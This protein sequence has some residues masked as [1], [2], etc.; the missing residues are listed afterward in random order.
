MILPAGGLMSQAINVDRCAKEGTLSDQTVTEGNDIESQVERLPQAVPQSEHSEYRSLARRWLASAGRESP[1]PQRMAVARGYFKLLAAGVWGVEENWRGDLRD[2]LCALW[3]SDEDQTNASSEQLADLSS[4]IAIGLALLLQEANLH[5]GA[6]ADLIARFAW[7]ECQEWA[8]YAEE[9][10]IARFLVPS[11]QPHARV[12][13]E[14]EVQAVVELAMAAADDPNA[15]VIAALDAEGF[16]AE[17]IDGVWVID[18][19]FR[20]PLRVAARAAT[21]IGSPCVVLARNSHKSN[22][23]LWRDTILAMADSAVPRWRI[24]RIVPPTTP[25]SK[26]RG[27]EG[28]PSTRDIHPLVP[29]PEQVRTL[30]EQAG[31]ALPMLLAAL[32]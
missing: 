13:S 32:R 2:L 8:A 24:Y 12:T 31:V 4:L 15:E 28:L 10:V 27:G 19:D 21:L 3:P 29:A 11:T 30:A 1:L 16:H 9:P 14:S 26:F 23:L 7:D 5:G 18:G 22:V 25:Q 17:L 20:T 6:G